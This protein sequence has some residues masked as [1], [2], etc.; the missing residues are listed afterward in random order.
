MR[1]RAVIGIAL[2]IASVAVL[3]CKA[4]RDTE[5]EEEEEESHDNYWRAQLVIEGNGAAV[6]SIPA[7]EC[8]ASNGQ[9]TGECGPKLLTFKELAPPLVEAQAAQGWRFDRWRSVLRER[10]GTTHPRPG[11][12]PDGKRYLNGM[13]YT[14]TGVLETVTAIFVRDADAKPAPTH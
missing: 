2:L 14:D 9:Q 5:E 6:T 10:D 4:C 3:D 13:G 12:M 11:R 1:R 7:F 8:R